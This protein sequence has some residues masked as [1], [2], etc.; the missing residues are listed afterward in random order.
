MALEKSIATSGKPVRM[1]ES[2]PA[3]TNNIGT[4]DASLLPSIPTG[5]NNIGKLDIEHTITQM[6]TG[7]STTTPLGIGGI[8][9][10]VSEEIKDFA[11]VHVC[12]FADQNNAVD[13]MCVQWSCDEVNWDLEECF[14]ITANKVRQH[15]FGIRGR[16]FR[17]VYINGGVVQGTFRLEVAYHTVRSQE[18]MRSL[19]RDIEKTDIVSTKRVIIAAQKPS[20][21]DYTNIQCT[22]GGNLKMSLEEYDD[23]FIN[24]PLP[25]KDKALG[26]PTTT[27]LTLTT[28]DTAYLI[29][30]TEL[31]DR[32]T[33]IIHN[34]SDTDIYYGDSGVTTTNGILLSASGTVSLDIESELYAVCGTNSK[35]INILELK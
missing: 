3:G 34:K 33:V 31:T 32:R 12:V 26:T 1:T 27:A 19:R 8:F 35:I 28:A 9:T 17:I 30:A 6:S 13:G 4:V 7:N 25:V 21:G 15:E 18:V 14:N 16:Y 2:I 10:G 29:P 5:T 23:T 11:S 20:D 22:T 24:N